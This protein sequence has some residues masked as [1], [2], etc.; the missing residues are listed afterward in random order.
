MWFF[1][2]AASLFYSDIKT[3]TKQRTATVIESTPA[4]LLNIPKQDFPSR[5]PGLAAACNLRS[6]L[7]YLGTPWMNW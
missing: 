4:P 3:S 1:G 7:S 6:S 2:I 5:F